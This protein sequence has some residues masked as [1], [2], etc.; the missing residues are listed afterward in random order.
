MESETGHCEMIE[1]WQRTLEQ[2]LFPGN[3]IIEIGRSFLGAPYRTGTLEKAGREN[4]MVNLA[5]FDCTTFVE[6]VLAL[7]CSALAGKLSLPEFRKN[8]KFIRYRQGRMEGYASRLHYF[9]DW[10][11]D[12]EKKNVLKDISRL[13][14]GVPRRKKINFMTVHRDLYAGLKN[15]AA[16]GN[17]SR[18]EK[19]LSRKIFYIIGKEKMARYQAGIHDGDVIAF[20]ASQDGLD[21]AHAGFALRQGKHLHLLHASSREGAVVISKET[22]GSFLKANKKF[23]GIL[24][25]RYS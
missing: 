15:K 13:L 22:L 9:S 4:L 23:D 17:L 14:G 3:L 5:E 21:I 6:T 24:I 8:L 12:N 20:A 2:D 10:L 7:A 16:F 11:R 1:L 25:A 18:V 19:N